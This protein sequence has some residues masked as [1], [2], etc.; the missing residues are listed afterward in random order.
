[1]T[2]EDEEL[3]GE[4]LNSIMT[5]YGFEYF[6]MGNTAMLFL[7]VW[8]GKLRKQY[9]GSIQLDY[10]KSINNQLLSFVQY[11]ISLEPQV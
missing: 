7:K 2:K 6:M 10:S 8:D 5:Q 11:V 9:F 3:I 1:M 4:V